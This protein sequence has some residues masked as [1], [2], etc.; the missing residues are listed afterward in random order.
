M[1]LGLTPLFWFRNG[2]LIMGGDFVISL[3]P[4]NIFFQELL[5]W[6]SQL[7]A[8]FPSFF[9]TYTFPFNL[10]WA[11]LNLVGLS[12]VTIEKFWFVSIFVLPGLT[13][14]YLLSVL[15]PDKKTLIPRAVASIFYM[16]N[17]FL[18]AINPTIFT[19]YLAIGITPLLLGLLIKGIGEKEKQNRYIF[20][21][22]L[23]SLLIIPVAANPPM[24]AVVWLVLA[25]Y[26][27]F[28]FLF[29]S[30]RRMETIFFSVKA[31][32]IFILLNVWWLLIFISTL[33]G[34]ELTTTKIESWMN[35]TTV[36]ASFLNIFRLLGSWSW[37]SD[38]FGSPYVSYV[39][40]YSHPL[41]ISA[42]FIIPILAFWVLLFKRRQRSL[43]F[44]FL[45][46]LSAIFLAK[47]S[48]APLELINKWLFINV[49]FF[50]LFRGPWEK[51][52]FVVAMGYG[53]LSCL[54]ISEILNYLRKQKN[55]I[56][57]I[58]SGIFI[59][60]IL[61]AIFIASYPMFSGDIIRGNPTIGNY[62][63]QRVL[64][65]SYWFEASTWIDKQ[66]IDSRILL[67]PMNPG[68][69]VHYEWGY[70]GVD[71]TVRLLSS[72]LVV[73]GQSSYIICQ[74]THDFIDVIYKGLLQNSPGN[75]I[76]TVNLFN[77][78][79][80][81]QR[82]DF[83]WTN[84]GSFDGGSP[85]F[86][87]NKL[88]EEGI[89]I[90]QSFGKL[91]YYA[92]EKKYFLPHFYTPQSIILSADSLEALPEIVSQKDYNIR[93]AIYFN[94]QN[95]N[96][97]DQ[98]L[99]KSSVFTPLFNNADKSQKEN[100]F[101]LNKYQADNIF[102]LNKTNSPDSLVNVQYSPETQKLLVSSLPIKGIFIN[103]GEIVIKP[104]PLL[105][106][107]GRV[108]D[109]LKIGE[110][111]FSVQGGYSKIF[112]FSE[113]VVGLE[114][115]Q[116]KT[117]NKIELRGNSFEEG[118]W[119]EAPGDCRLDMAGKADIKMR[120]SL[121]ATQGRY[122]LELGS[123]NHF[124]CVSKSFPVNLKKDKLYKYSFDYKSVKGK[125]ISYYYNL[126]GREKSSSFIELIEVNNQEWNHYEI[127][128]KPEEDI[129]SIDLFFYAPSD[130]TQEVVNKY[131]N[132]RLSEVE[133]NKV[134]PDEINQ[135]KPASNQ[136]IKNDIKLLEG[137]NTIEYKGNMETDGTLPKDFY[138]YYLQSKFQEKIKTPIIEF[139]KINPTKYRVIIHHAQDEFPLVF[140]ESFNDGWKSYLADYQK[141][142]LN[143]NAADYKIIDGNGDDQASAEELKSFISSGLISSLGDLKAKNIKHV[144]WVDNKE[145]FDYNEGY[146][147]DFI[148]KNF[149]DTIQNDN[150]EPGNFYETWFKEPVDGNKNH[151]M[152]NGYANSW[153]F[154]PNEL[155]GA[156]AGKALCV[157]NADG[158]YD[159]EL[160]V[161]FWPQRLF[162]LG[163][164]ISGATLL[165]CLGYL[166]WD[167]VKRR[168]KKGNIE[169]ELKED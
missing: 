100:R 57:F 122:S 114:T 45:L 121:D 23:S 59:L 17:P 9:T 82:N 133:I 8:G 157:R 108:G 89:N 78:N 161:E 6:F 90:R 130:G 44:F 152:V 94:Q 4:Q 26:L 74:K 34:V 47:G 49:P 86:I 80:I 55:K 135:N 140:S 110:N 13:M 117:I 3:N 67:S 96:I 163:L 33:R 50:W 84:F 15:F 20:L 92:L 162:Y 85:E 25:G 115:Y 22:G 160:V 165:G 93:S 126:I 116:V 18:L 53:V 168:K 56:G 68:L 136:V 155:C 29:L 138:N 169:G 149:Q 159:L 62:P 61:V 39:N 10:F 87:K 88:A 58:A 134:V 42:T 73:A 52:V 131:D 105:E 71:S 27:L 60:F 70:Q 69:Y 125:E 46:I 24:F 95:L 150:L 154:N 75:L 132:I 36:N 64:I 97:P 107:S 72:S 158:S 118:L 103:D 101:I 19:S 98:L 21:F 16:F 32:G 144:K 37:T 43:L 153:N 99:N 66:R 128:I 48:H 41:F 129:S 139:K 111:Y 124:A 143:F 38:A 35:W 164:F 112:K 51:F 120:L 123:K 106:V 141:N 79:S 63:G 113:I 65:P 28:Y 81:L 31:V 109:F 83:D 7:N 1:L 167:F 127:I 30:K 166:G 145:V 2:T 137:D 5:P 147:I 77:I 54:A 91:D 146:K 76:K 156:P 102:I 104:S 11:L 14:Y 119:Q 12:L 148:S 151:L 142:S 40:L